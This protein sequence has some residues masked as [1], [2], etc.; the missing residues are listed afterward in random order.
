MAGDFKIYVEDT[1]TLC[2][3]CG[4]PISEDDGI[5][6]HKNAKIHLCDKCL[7]NR[8]VNYCK[9]WHRMNKTYHNNV[10]RKY[11]EQYR[12]EGKEK[13][14]LNRFWAKTAKEKQKEYTDR[15]FNKICDK[16]NISRTDAHRLGRTGLIRYL[17]EDNV[18]SLIELS[19]IKQRENY[20]KRG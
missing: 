14:A 3:C 4:K 17:L 11:A 12:A 16:Y 1:I 18:E 5:H 10:M 20:K 13:E 2:D 19:K 7:E 8:T 15:Y 6:R 9:V